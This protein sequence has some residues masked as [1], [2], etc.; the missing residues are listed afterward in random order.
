[1]NI[2]FLETFIWVAR[3]N[4]FRLTAERLFT[5]QAA[6]SGRIA[7]LEAE[8]G[9]RLFLR[10]ARGATLTAEGRAALAHAEQI[11]ETYQALRQSADLGGAGRLRLGVIDSVVH[12]WLAPLMGELQ[13]RFPAL[14]VELQVDTARPLLEL[15][16]RGPLDL[17][18]QTD[19]LASDSLRSVRLL[20]MRMA[21]LARRDGTE[22][23]A[24]CLA[25]LAGERLLTFSRHSR[26]HQDLL[27]LL[28]AAG[29]ATPR[30]SCINS[31]AAMERLLLDGYGVA[32][33]PP[34]LLAAAEAQ[35]VRELALDGEPA[36]LEVVASWRVGAG[37]EWLEAVVD[38]CQEVVRH[39]CAGRPE[40]VQE[41]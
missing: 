27:S 5:T 13:K 11:L 14:E 23:G 39:Y 41:G 15:L 36:A 29:I 8:L 28:H 20:R 2:K 1:M 21:W 25:D 24:R 18:L 33:M 17:A 32:V 26:P 35:G 9:V 37:L 19:P 3:L 30:V 7:A 31:L 10:D 12:S 22:P 38:C 40:W 6:V 4:S 16:R 34:A